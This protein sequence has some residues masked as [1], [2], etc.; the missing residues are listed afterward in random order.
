MDERLGADTRDLH[1]LG[2]P[3]PAE[4]DNHANGKP[5]LPD[6][7]TRNRHVGTF[8][9]G[10]GGFLIVSTALTVGL[11][12]ERYDGHISPVVSLT[13]IG[14]FSAL[15]TACLAAGM[16][17]KLNQY[18]RAQTRRAIL[19]Q[20]AAV[21]ERAADRE[22]HAEDRA[23][24]LVQLAAVGYAI[25]LVAQHLPEHDRIVNWRGFNDAVKQG[26]LG[27][28]TGTDWPRDRRHLGVVKPG[29]TGPTGI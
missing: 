24:L 22:R 28:H 18:Q 23:A 3:H 7:E 5:R 14:M 27:E 21:D 6:R 29:K 2:E 16:G 25:D 15:G 26:F 11:I 9:L 19:G 8:L 13:L 12:P 17:E 4:A 20:Q 10:A 1:A